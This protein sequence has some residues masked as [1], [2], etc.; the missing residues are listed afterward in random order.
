MKIVAV[1]ANNAGNYHRLQLPLSRIGN[2][3]FV[4]KILEADIADCDI[5]Y[6][7]WAC[8]NNDI[9]ELSIWREKY[10]FK[11]ILDLDDIWIEGE[12][13]SFISMNTAI[14]ADHVICSTQYIADR[15]VK[16]N[17]STSVIPNRIP[18]GE[19]QFI[20]RKSGPNNKIK[21][22]ISGSISHFDDWMSLKPFF[23]R[24][25]QDKLIMD[26][27]EF[28][29]VGYENTKKWNTVVSIFP[30]N[31]EI[32]EAVDYTEYMYLMDDIDIL[33][34]PLLDTPL[35]RG[36]SSLKILEAHCK[37]AVIFSN[38]LYTE[39]E[40]KYPGIIYKNWLSYLHLFCK[41][42]DLLEQKVNH[43]WE[44][45]QEECVESRKRIFKQLVEEEERDEEYSHI[46][47]SISY[48]DN[49]EVEYY[50]VKN[51]RKTI[52]EKSY[53]FEYNIILEQMEYYRKTGYLDALPSNKYIGFFSWKFPWK[54]GFFKKIVYQ[55]LDKENADIVV[56]CKPI[57]NYFQDTEKYHPGFK[58][59]FE[60][61]CNKLDLK[62]P[63]E[64]RVCVYSNF[65][66]AKKTIYWDYTLLLEQAINILET[67]LKDLC[68]KDSG[69]QGLTKEELKQRTG[70]DYYPFHTFLL[71][72]LVSVWIENNPGLKVKTYY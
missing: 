56:F 16:V 17:P 26:N 6:I 65:F 42:R 60:A 25:K 10:A 44:D 58:E 5:L 46:I 19:G 69:Y 14:L 72:R 55:I 22:G 59:I 24:V 52:K 37:N 31:P 29:V 30:K 51:H 9:P 50:P 7:H 39:E 71:E 12:R 63:K 33:L 4:N 53:L 54:T 57:K 18:F 34:C 32:R 66:V 41:R 2:V 67:D 36:R 70:L 40:T 15:V 28:V 62:I 45:Y 20:P 27:V 64:P 43:K 11:I 35:N 13:S 3:R 8:P 48:A 21:I 61:L 49:Q 47:T 38:K 23:K 1:Q 68:W